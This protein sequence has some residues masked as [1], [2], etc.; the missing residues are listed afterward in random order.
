MHLGTDWPKPTPDVAVSIV[1]N[2]ALVA[3]FAPLNL[4]LDNLIV[5]FIKL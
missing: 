1:R 3:S 4:C 2:D 5:L